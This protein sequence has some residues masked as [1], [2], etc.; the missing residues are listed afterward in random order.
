MWQQT[1]K[2]N[3]AKKQNFNGKI[4]DSKFE[5][6]EAQELELRKRGRDI[7]DYRTQVT[8]PLYIRN[9]ITKEKFNLGVYIADFVVEH[10]DGSLEI[11]ETKGKIFATPHF[12]MKWKMVEALYGHEYK[13]TCIMQGNGRLRSPKKVIE[14]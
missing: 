5:A 3:T 2:W 4:Y 6:G 11:R 8:F 9:E 14:Y 13:M 1:T 10:N 7:K 12:R